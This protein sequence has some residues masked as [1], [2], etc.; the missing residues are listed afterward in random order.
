MTPTDLA[1]LISVIREWSWLVSLVS[2]PVIY[3]LG[4]RAG[5][6]RRRKLNAGHEFAQLCDALAAGGRRNA[7]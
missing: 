6:A 5:M 2:G 3:W 7:V 4:V 1:H